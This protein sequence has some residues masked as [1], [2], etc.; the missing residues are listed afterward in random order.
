[1]KINTLTN[2]AKVPFDVEGYLMHTSA[3][4]EVIHLCLQ[5]GQAIPPHS[6]PID[7]VAC[8]V[9]GEA[10]LQTDKIQVKLELYAVVEI[11]KDVERGFTNN[12]KSEARLLI[13]KKF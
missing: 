12:G 9:E 11:E 2:A 5:P 3:S 7:I 6:N 8:L 4:L 13:M 10:T 1:M